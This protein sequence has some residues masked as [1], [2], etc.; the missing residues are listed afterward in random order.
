MDVAASNS[1]Q[2]TYKVLFWGRGRWE[3]E[4]SK[5]RENIPRPISFQFFRTYR[6]HSLPLT[7][8]HLMSNY[9][10]P[11]L[12]MPRIRPALENS[13]ST[14]HIKSDPPPNTRQNP[15]LVENTLLF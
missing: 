14:P 1:L 5:A 15:G 10:M 7:F 9:S 4:H 11:G 2:A 6:L 12:V 3:G 13:Q 8:L